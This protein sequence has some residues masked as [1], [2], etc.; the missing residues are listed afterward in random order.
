VASVVA[1]ASVVGSV[2]AVA[3]GVVAEGTG[4]V[5]VAVAVPVEVG[6]EVEVAVAVAL[7]G[8]G[9]GVPGDLVADGVIVF[10]PVAVGGTGVT[11]PPPDVVT[12]RHHPP[13]IWP[14]SPAASSTTY[15]LQVPLAGVPSNTERLLV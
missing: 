8:L 13:A 11:V 10:V 14:I 7:G 5:L 6:G 3:G 15:R 1:V 9:V 12:S 2:V 4:S